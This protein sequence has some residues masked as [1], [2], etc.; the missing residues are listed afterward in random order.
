MKLL[1][2][3]YLDLYL[4]HWPLCYSSEERRDKDDMSF[5]TYP[6]K[7]EDKLGYQADTLLQVYHVMEEL[8]QEV[9]IRVYSRGK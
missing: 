1:Q 6:E 8:V 5:Y 3:D 4:I 9:N 2:V 7:D